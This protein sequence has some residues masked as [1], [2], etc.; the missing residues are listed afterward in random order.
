MQHITLLALG[1]STAAS[2]SLL[3]RQVQCSDYSSDDCLEREGEYI[4]AVCMPTNATGY[5]DFNAPCVAIEAITAECMYG[6][7]GLSGLTGGDGSDPTEEPAMLS[8][9]T[10]RTC[11]C[12]SQFFA[13][14]VGCEACY[15][16][17]GAADDES[18]YMAPSLISSISLTY[19]AVTNTPTLGIADFLYS[20]A[21]ASSQSA[22]SASEVTGSFTDPIGN[23]TAVSYYFTPSITGSAAYIVAEATESVSI[24]GIASASASSGSASSVSTS[25]HTSDGMIVPT[26]SAAGA[27]GSASSSGSASGSAAT[28]STTGSSGAGKQ[29]AAAVAGVI[30]LAAFVAII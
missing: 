26:A 27:A 12:E 6:S 5:P 13:Q 3:K 19:C 8:I 20:Y 18:G 22:S 23:K 28:A 24:S 17:H 30:A 9:S 10:Q 1:L 7:A 4:E 2:A 16:A 11:V 25:L 15:K 21:T 14:A 29:E